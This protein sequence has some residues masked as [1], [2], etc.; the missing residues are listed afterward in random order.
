MKLR[1]I[2]KSKIHHAVVTAADLECVGSVGISGPVI[3]GRSAR[4][5]DD[6]T[7]AG[8]GLENRKHDLDQLLSKV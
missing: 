5:T 3:G 4:R 6:E 8:P 1:V 7:P 2:C